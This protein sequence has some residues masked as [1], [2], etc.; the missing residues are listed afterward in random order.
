MPSPEP[1]LNIAT[2]PLP[3]EGG[4]R[5]PLCSGIPSNPSTVPSAMMDYSAL[6]SI[7]V[8]RMSEEES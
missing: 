1:E 7:P 6:S 5:V 4:Q 3:M 8:S 2:P